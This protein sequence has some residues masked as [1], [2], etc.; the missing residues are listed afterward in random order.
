MTAF[1]SERE[2]F[3]QAIEYETDFSDLFTQGIRD[4]IQHQYMAI[5]VIYDDLATVQKLIRKSV[6]NII[7]RQLCSRVLKAAIKVSGGG[8]V[9]ASFVGRRGGLQP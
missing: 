3:R 5:A 9:G 1:I 2:N 4:A 8:S 6:V 7:V